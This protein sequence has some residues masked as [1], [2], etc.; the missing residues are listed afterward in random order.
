MTT[1]PIPEWASK[2][3]TVLVMEPGGWGR[4]RHFIN[5]E[6]TRVTKASV[7]V[8]VAGPNGVLS[9]GATR[10]RRFVPSSWSNDTERMVEYGQSTA[11][12][13]STYIWNPEYEGIKDA[14]ERGR[15]RAL[16]L[17]VAKAAK[18]LAEEIDRSGG[19]IPAAIAELRRT[20]DAYEADAK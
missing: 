9:G 5:V 10:E 18:N 17:K 12:G 4:D 3:G 13:P 1:K 19:H 6:I 2:P 16:E 14:I 11:W 20:L 8:K 15:V 7:F